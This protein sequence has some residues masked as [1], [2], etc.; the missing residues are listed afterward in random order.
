VT[1]LADLTRSDRQRLEDRLTEL[2]ELPTL[3]RNPE[4]C[5][6]RPHRRTQRPDGGHGGERARFLVTVQYGDLGRYVVRQGAA[7]R[8]AFRD[9]HRDVS[10]ASLWVPGP[11]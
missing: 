10:L 2:R 4:A 3:M 6:H 11:A 5:P 9:S 1:A 8:L 7:G